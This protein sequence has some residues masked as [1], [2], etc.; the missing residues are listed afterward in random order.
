MK[1]SSMCFDGED[2]EID[3][4]Q[5]Y[6]KLV[7]ISHKL[8]SCFCARIIESWLNAWATTERL[9]LEK[10]RQCIF[11]RGGEDALNHYLLCDPL[12]TALV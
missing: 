8:G 3:W 7:P 11:G 5:V 9:Q 6:D 2:T 1:A 12:W 10:R 4:R